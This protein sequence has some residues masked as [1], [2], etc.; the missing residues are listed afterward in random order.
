MPQI[1]KGS[2]SSEL[3]KNL[4]RKYAK[5][6]LIIHLQVKKF[7]SSKEEFSSIGIPFKSKSFNTVQNN[8]ESKVMTSTYI[9]IL[10]RIMN[11]ILVVFGRWKGI[12]PS[13]LPNNENEAIGKTLIHLLC[14]NSKN[15]KTT[16]W[17][18]NMGV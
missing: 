8:F 18:T 11:M 12:L 17:T 1:L 6:H 5:A 9:Y 10:I 13:Q 7:T 15:R 2:L 14:L 4:V 16:N 3:D